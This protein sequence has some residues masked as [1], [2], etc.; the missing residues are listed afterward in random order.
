MSCYYLRH[1]KSKYGSKSTVQKVDGALKVSC[2]VCFDKV[3]VQLKRDDQKLSWTLS[4]YRLLSLVLTT[5]I[6]DRP[7]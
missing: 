2:Q 1:M 6:V 7:F 4:H 3:V 5:F